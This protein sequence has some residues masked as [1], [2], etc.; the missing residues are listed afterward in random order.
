LRC[1]SQLARRAASLGCISLVTFFVQAKKVTRPLPTL[2]A[3]EY[4]LQDGRKSPLTYQ[5][6]WH[7]FARL[8]D[9]TSHKACLIRASD[10]SCSCKKSNQKNT[11]LG[12]AL[13]ASRERSASG[14]AVP[15]Q[16][17]CCD[18]TKQAIHGL[19]TSPSALRSRR[20]QN[21]DMKSSIQSRAFGANIH[22]TFI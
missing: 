2:F 12:V 17:P 7:C 20:P 5:G 8:D 19:F 22:Q 21:G 1:A 16:H 14:K 6:R 18:G 11:P 3:T 9:A 13:R 15:T 4:S 10:F